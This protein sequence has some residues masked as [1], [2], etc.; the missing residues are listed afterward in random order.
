M[1][2]EKPW[3]KYP[4]T[5]LTKKAKPG[6]SVTVTYAVGM[7]YNG[8]I[9]EKGEWF[10]GYEVPPPIVPEGFKLVGIGIGLCLN[11]APPRAT[12]ILRQI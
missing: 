4:A 8:G 2:K 9:V 6:K 3:L 11:S 10:A 12:A 7:S 1:S 5:D